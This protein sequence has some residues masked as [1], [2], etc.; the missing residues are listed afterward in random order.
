MFFHLLRLEFGI[1][2]SKFRE[3]AHMSPFQAQSSFQEIYEFLEVS[4]VLV[5]INEVFQL[6]SVNDNMKST[7]LG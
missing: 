5:V 1:Q 3:H 2:N 7:H 4:P 6:V